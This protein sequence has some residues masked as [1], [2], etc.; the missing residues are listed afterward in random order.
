[1]EGWR[2]VLCGCA[3]RRAWLWRR[4]GK[5]TSAKHLAARTYTH[6]KC[7]TEIIQ[8]NPRARVACVIHP[9]LIEWD[10]GRYG[11]EL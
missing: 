4:Q 7:T 8:D 1:M 6:G 11:E 10:E 2:D 3:M 9:E 5:E